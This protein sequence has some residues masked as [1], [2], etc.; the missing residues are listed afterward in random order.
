[1]GEF[2]GVIMEDTKSFLDSI[3]REHPRNRITGV[4]NQGKVLRFQF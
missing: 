4:Y 3:F 2:L 1:M